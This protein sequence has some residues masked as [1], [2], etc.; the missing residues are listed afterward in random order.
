VSN[1]EKIAD[2]SEEKHRA[3]LTARKQ[4]SF[5]IIAGKVNFPGRREEK[6]EN[7]KTQLAN[8]AQ[9]G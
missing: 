5:Q 9:S 2:D 3:P 7:N 1:C 6:H 4:K 8:H